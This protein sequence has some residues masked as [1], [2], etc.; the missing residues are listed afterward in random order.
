MGALIY[1]GVLVTLKKAFSFTLGTMAPSSL[2][3]VARTLYETLLFSLKHWPFM[4]FN[5][6]LCFAQ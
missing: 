5:Q 3:G 1:G 2:L 6:R 4:L